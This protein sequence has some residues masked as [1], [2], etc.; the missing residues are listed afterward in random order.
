MRDMT[1]WQPTS[2]ASR[3]ISLADIGHISFISALGGLE[4]SPNIFKC[5]DLSFPTP[6]VVIK[7]KPNFDPLT[8]LYDLLEVHNLYQ[9]IALELLKNMRTILIGLFQAVSEI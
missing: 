6:F 8:S 4:T 2:L 7:W 9:S 3:L 1:N 5:W